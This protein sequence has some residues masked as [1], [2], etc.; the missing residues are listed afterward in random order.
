MKGSVMKRLQKLG[1]TVIEAVWLF[2]VYV[3][4]FISENVRKA[5]DFIRPRR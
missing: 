1:L 3:W 5:L 2:F 4:Y